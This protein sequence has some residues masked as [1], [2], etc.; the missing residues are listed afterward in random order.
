LDLACGPTDLTGV[1]ISGPCATGD[2]SPS[3]YVW[4]PNSNYVSF[5]SAS[6]GV[7][8]VELTFATGFIYSAD[9]TFA[10]QTSGTHECTPCPAFIAPTQS[11]FMVNDPNTTCVGAGVDAG[12]DE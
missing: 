7:C 10:Y 12:M 5:T 3:N 6:P 8:H 11:M 1:T 2:A 4:G 9:V